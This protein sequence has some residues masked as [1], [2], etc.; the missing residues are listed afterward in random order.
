[1][2][3]SHRAL[4]PP[5]TKHLPPIRWRIMAQTPTDLLRACSPREPH[6]GWHSACMSSRPWPMPALPPLGCHSHPMV[7]GGGGGL[8]PSVTV[9]ICLCLNASHPAPT[10]ISL[11]THTHT[12]R[13]SRSALAPSLDYKGGSQ[14]AV[15]QTRYHTSAESG[16]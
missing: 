6:R 10:V 4:G 15:S 1:M 9:S 7:D 11:H 3:V 2:A 5:W 12:E 8:K 14:K 16:C 13:T